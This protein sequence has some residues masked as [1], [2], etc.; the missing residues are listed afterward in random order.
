MPFAAACL[1]YECVLMDIYGAD[2]S[3]LIL[4]FLSEQVEVHCATQNPDTSEFDRTG[5]IHSTFYHL[6]EVPTQRGC[7]YVYLQ[8]PAYHTLQKVQPVFEN[9]HPSLPVVL[10]IYD[11]TSDGTLY[12]PYCFDIAGVYGL[13]TKDNVYAACDFCQ[14]CFLL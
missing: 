12:C 10:S 3:G 4:S 9:T 7:W 2:I 14:V 8:E 13:G 1:E 11:T 6:E 5:I